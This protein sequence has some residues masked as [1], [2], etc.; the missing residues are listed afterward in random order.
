MAD[1]ATGTD[2]SSLRHDP[3]V[4]TAGHPAASP[5]EIT[6]PDRPL[7]TIAGFDADATSAFPSPVEPGCLQADGC[8]DPGFDDPDADAFDFLGEGDGDLCGIPALDAAAPEDGP[9]EEHFSCSAPADADASVPITDGLISL[10]DV[11]L[12]H[13][14]QVDADEDATVTVA[15]LNSTSWAAARR[16]IEKGDGLPSV[17]FL[18]EHHLAYQSDIDEAQSFLLKAGW[19]GLFAPAAATPEG[20]AAQ[21]E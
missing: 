13:V 21:Q 4:F 11:P 7:E 18:Q 3:E 8:L 14:A 12:V 17:L 1:E 19:K 20:G 2:C 16:V 5:A 15:T 6:L 9:P 10:P